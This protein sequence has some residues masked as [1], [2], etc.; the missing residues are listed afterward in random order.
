MVLEL[1]SM[2]QNEERAHP[3]QVP[4]LCPGV[5]TQLLQ[6]F[7]MC[8]IACCCQTA[9]KMF[10][11]ERTLVCEFEFRNLSEQ[12]NLKTV[13]LELLQEHFH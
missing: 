2:Q 13:I 12:P 11:A 4:S 1:K 6:L 7:D 10:P 5:S 8:I 9:R 3:H